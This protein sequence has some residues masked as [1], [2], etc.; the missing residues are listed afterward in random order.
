MAETGVTVEKLPRDDRAGKHQ[1]VRTTRH[2]DDDFLGALHGLFFA[3][4]LA[5]SRTGVDS[6]ESPAL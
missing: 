4:C 5:I 6:R 3:G 2:S 1:H